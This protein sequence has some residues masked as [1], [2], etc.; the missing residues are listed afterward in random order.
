MKMLLV[1]A[2]LVGALAVGASSRSGHVASPV[3]QE[4]TSEPARCVWRGRVKRP[5]ERLGETG[6]L[7]HL[8]VVQDYLAPSASHPDE[9]TVDVSYPLVARDY[10]SSLNIDADQQ[11]GIN[12]RGYV[13]DDGRCVVD[14]LGS[15]RGRPGLE[16]YVY[17]PED[18]CPAPAPAMAGAR[19]RSAW[20]LGC[21]VGPELTVTTPEQGFQHGRMLYLGGIYVLEAA[22]ASDS[23]SREHWSGVQ[24]TFRNTEP[25]QTGLAP[26]AG[27]FEPARGFGKAWREV[28]GGPTGPLGWATEAEHGEPLTWQQFGSGIVALDQTGAGWVMYS[29]GRW[30]TVAP[31][32]DP[33]ARLGPEPSTWVLAIAPAPSWPQDPL[34]LAATPD[35]L[36]RT[37]DGGATW[38]ALAPPE[39]DVSFDDRYGNPVPFFALAPAPG[40]GPPVAFFLGTHPRFT[41]YRSTD[42]G[43][44]WAVAL[45]SAIGLELSPTFAQ[46][47]LAF[48]VG[49]GRLYRSRD[50]GASWEEV[51]PAADQRIG[52]VVLSPDFARDHTLY[53][54]A[55]SSTTPTRS[56]DLDDHER[57]RG[58]LVSTDGGATWADASAG[59]AVD[60]TPYRNVDHLVVSPTF[61]AD[62]TLFAFALG[63][64]SPARSI[65][66]Y[67]WP[68][69]LFRSRDRGRSWERV[70]VPLHSNGLRPHF[71]LSADFAHDGEA[72][73]AIN[74]A[75]FTPAQSS[76][77]VFET[78][79]A[80][81]TWSLVLPGQ[82]YTGCGDVHALGMGPDFRAIV[83]RN[84][85]SW[86]GS[87]LPR[88]SLVPQVLAGPGGWPRTVTRSPAY[89]RD[90]T[91]LLGTA[92]GIWRYTP[93]AAAGLAAPATPSP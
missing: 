77:N 23:A 92:D 47:G 48:A 15:E 85:G 6:L 59:L 42:A 39:P 55:V 56:P 46:D 80:G 21:P 50:A 45:R 81:A 68:G 64:R 73:V 11:M 60:E 3:R 30:E 17:V 34:L 4:S 58:V 8:S 43:S 13:G 93:A 82:Q 1:V 2:A 66:N 86:L 5:V 41:L 31:G 49:D 25:A 74:A 10:Y 79:D 72:V 7:I 62:G 51:Q 70:S 40:G 76:C 91:L 37:R 61:G 63:P 27:L 53:V 38:E 65:N 9:E 67:S 35:G 36:V 57:S 89:W 28:Y 20:A 26:P 75:G 83:S 12:V 52:E 16:G 88:Q 71:A 84:G 69:Q 14:T 22:D 78:R 18:P 54:V 29:D 33:W 24:N 19:E 87:I 44:S 32:A 90:R